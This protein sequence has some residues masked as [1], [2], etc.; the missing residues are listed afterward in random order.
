[1]TEKRIRAQQVGDWARR[2]A[3]KSSPQDRMLTDFLRAET[4]EEKRKVIEAF[5]P[6]YF[7]FG[8]KLKPNNVRNEE[9]DG[10]TL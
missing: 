7:V 9:D 10:N 1:M 4:A 6:Y 5:A 3:K 8:K 2:K